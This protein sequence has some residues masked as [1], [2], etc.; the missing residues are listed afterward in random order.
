MWYPDAINRLHRRI[1]KSAGLEHI[2]LHAL[3][4]TL[5]HGG[6]VKRGVDV[7][8]VSDMLG[9]SNAGF[10]LRTYTHVTTKMQEQAADT[11]GQFISRNM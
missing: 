7:K 1:L 5:R 10:T 9:H 11:M 2:R 6:L 3:R 4:H 8:T